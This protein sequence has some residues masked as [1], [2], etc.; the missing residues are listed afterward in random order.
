MPQW[1]K[2]SPANAGVTGDTGSTP[3]SGK[4]PR[5]RNG[6]PLQY[7]CQNKPIGRGPWPAMVHEVTKSQT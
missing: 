3:G 6:N 2:N 5:G 1:L 4:S 7:S